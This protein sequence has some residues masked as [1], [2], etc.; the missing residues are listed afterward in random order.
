MSD[1]D[2]LKFNIGAPHLLST[3]EINLGF[4][5]TDIPVKYLD[6]RWPGNRLTKAPKIEVSVINS[7]GSTQ[8]ATT[9][10]V[11]QNGILK[12]RANGFHY[13]SPTISVKGVTEVPKPLSS[14]TPSKQLSKTKKVLCIK[15]KVTKSFEGTSCPVGWKKK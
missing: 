15:G 9:S 3:G 14:S 11:V 4:F 5:S 7:D 6:C 10:V 8:I 13:S 1:L 2:T 12:V